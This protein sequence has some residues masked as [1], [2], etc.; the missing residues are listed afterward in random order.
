[1]HRE[2]V[3]V[4]RKDAHTDY[5]YRVALRALIRNDKGEILIVKEKS[6]DW[7]DLP[8]G[9]LDYGESIEDGL[10]RELVEEVGLTGE[11]D[12]TILV[13]QE[14][15][16]NERLGAMQLNVIY[17]VTPRDMNFSLGVDSVEWTFRSLDEIRRTIP[18]DS[19]LLAKLRAVGADRPLAY[20]QST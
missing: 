19:L 4:V 5:L 9:G 1:M 13:L 3:G 16:W 7:W 17:E 18:P 6:H 2:E 14:P 20:K 12:Y 10:K 11:F 8:G 15:S